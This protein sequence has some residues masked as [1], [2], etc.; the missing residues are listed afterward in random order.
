VTTRLIRDRFDTNLCYRSEQ[1]QVSTWLIIICNRC[2]SYSGDTRARYC[3]RQ[4]HYTTTRRIGER[5]SGKRCIAQA[6]P[7][8][9]C[10]SLHLVVCRFVASTAN[11]THLII[12]NHLSNWDTPIKGEYTICMQLSNLLGYRS[13]LFASNTFW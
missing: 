11:Q 7:R 2:T 1:K 3:R 4:P 10:F 8:K 5:R 9:N 6:S 12:G 13:S